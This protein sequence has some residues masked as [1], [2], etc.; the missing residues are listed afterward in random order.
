MGGL[1][2]ALRDLPGSLPETSVSFVPLSLSH[3]PAGSGQLSG[4]S[5][6]SLAI[7]RS[8]FP[9]LKWVEVW[10]KLAPTCQ[11]LLVTACALKVRGPL[12]G[13]ISVWLDRSMGL[14]AKLGAA[15][16]CVCVCVCILAE[17]G[18]WEGGG[19]DHGAGG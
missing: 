8:V 19:A 5:W 13:S 9:S 16:C 4:W 7:F 3:C 18:A 6:P 17:G 14:S 1:L 11:W 12:S 15:M 10:V 2:A